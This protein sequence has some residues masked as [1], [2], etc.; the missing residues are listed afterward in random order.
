MDQNPSRFSA[1]A[2][3]YLHC[4]SLDVCHNRHMSFLTLPFL[5]EL[6]VHDCQQSRPGFLCR[7]APAVRAGVRF[8]DAIRH[9]GRFRD[10]RDV[11]GRSIGPKTPSL[12]PGAQDSPTYCPLRGRQPGTP[13]HAGMVGTTLQKKKPSRPCLRGL[14]AAS[15][16]AFCAGSSRR[17]AK[18]AAKSG[19]N[20]SH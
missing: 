7:S 3:M 1:P 8:A 15:W 17:Q 12:K 6:L 10:R 20:S 4:W 11:S 9:R 13:G 18:I 16:P 14:A 5:H 19:A 2:T